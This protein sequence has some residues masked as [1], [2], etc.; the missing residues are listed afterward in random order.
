MDK[1]RKSWQS[2]HNL[3]LMN[4]DKYL[5]LTVVIGMLTTACKPHA[6]ERMTAQIAHEGREQRFY[7]FVRNLLRPAPRGTRREIRLE[8]PFDSSNGTVNDYS[9]TV[10]AGHDETNPPT[11]DE[12][13]GY[14]RFR[15]DGYIDIFTVTRGSAFPNAQMDAIHNEIARTGSADFSRS[16][17][18]YPP[19]SER[20]LTDHLQ[21]MRRS[22]EAIVGHPIGTPILTFRSCSPTGAPGVCEPLG[23]WEAEYVMRP[24]INASWHV[25][26][27]L[28]PVHGQL[29]SISVQ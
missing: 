24:K 27:E 19:G 29:V 22:V 8:T 9:W 17:A 23:T 2:R 18:A 25:I 16:S 26:L 4:S 10:A 13:G 11:V 7:R 6:H 21:E 1:L 3:A 15:E 20:A 14:V 5:V 28:E 12:L